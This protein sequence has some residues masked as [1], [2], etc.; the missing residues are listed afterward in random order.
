MN[1][2]ERNKLI[3]DA[4]HNLEDSSYSLNNN[5][6]PLSQEQIDYLISEAT[7]LLTALENYPVK[8]N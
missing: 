6:L 3:Y 4:A 5:E 7:K 1:V 2:L 8:G